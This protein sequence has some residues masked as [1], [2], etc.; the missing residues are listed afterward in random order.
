[1][2]E[3]STLVT[4]AS[5]RRRARR[6]GNLRRRYE[7]KGFSAGDCRIPQTHVVHRTIVNPEKRYDDAIAE[8]AKSRPQDRYVTHPTALVYQATGV[9]TRG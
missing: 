1:M 6:D 5:N 9:T 7:G 3:L 8:L 4:L 2:P